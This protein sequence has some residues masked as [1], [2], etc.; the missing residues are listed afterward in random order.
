MK[1][2]VPI[3]AVLVSLALPAAVSARSQPYTSLQP[4]TPAQ[5]HYAT[6]VRLKTLLA[7]WPEALQSYT[8]GQCRR[9]SDRYGRCPFTLENTNVAPNLTCDGTATVVLS[10]PLGVRVSVDVF[11]SSCVSETGAPWSSW[12][13]PGSDPSSEEQEGPHVVGEEEITS[14]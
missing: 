1:R 7:E 2:I 4:L 8:V 5:D 6:S 9:V 3:L 11:L 12:P 14:S 13:G 10:R